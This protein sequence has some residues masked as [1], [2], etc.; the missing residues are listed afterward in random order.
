[1]TT[2]LFLI[3]SMNINGVGCSAVVEATDPNDAVNQWHRWLQEYDP[4]EYA[5]D[6]P[7]PPRMVFELPELTGQSCFFHWHRHDG[8][9]EH[10]I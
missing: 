4:E 7:T 10:E 3:E 2:K 8:V 1:M 9:V 5:K 6:Q